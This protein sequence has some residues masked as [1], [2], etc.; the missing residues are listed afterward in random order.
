MGSLLVTQTRAAVVVRPIDRVEGVLISFSVGAELIVLVVGVIEPDVV[1]LNV[2]S[3][4]VLVDHDSEAELGGILIV[5]HVENGG[6]LVTG[7]HF[8]D[9]DM[10]AWEQFIDATRG[11]ETGLYRRLSGPQT[12]IDGANAPYG[13]GLKFEETGGKRLTGHG[14][15]LRGWRCQRWHCADE[16]LSTIAMFNFEGGASDVAFKLMNIALGVSTSEPQRAEADT[17]WFG[18]WLCQD[19]GLVLSLEDAGCGRLKARFGTGPEMMDVE[20][21]NEA[22]S[23]M[24]TIRRDGDVIELLRDDENLRLMMNRIKGEARQDIIGRYHSDELNADLLLV[25]EGGAIYGAFE[26]FL[27]KSDMYPLYSAGADV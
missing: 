18:S 8:G 5:S 14:G 2:E 22:R 13:F 12:F 1:G 24:T 15:A 7:D 27:G 10:I 3:V 16:R 11:D 6:E 26:G 19:T 20:S 17:A 21:A 4:T 25:S 23:S 9:D